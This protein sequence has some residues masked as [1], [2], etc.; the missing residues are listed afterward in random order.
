MELGSPLGGR[1]SGPGFLSHLIIH[2]SPPLYRPAAAPRKK[3]ECSFVSAT[4]RHFD[5]LLAVSPDNRRAQKQLPLA[6]VSG[7]QRRKDKK[8][9]GSKERELDKRQ[10][11]RGDVRI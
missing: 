2:A 5:C 11:A 1:L 3:A 8:R 6:K 4:G 10:T 9:R 7:R